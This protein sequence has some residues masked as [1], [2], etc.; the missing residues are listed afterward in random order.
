[1]FL[2][3]HFLG[4]NN[5]ILYNMSIYLC[6]DLYIDVHVYTIIINVIICTEIL[7]VGGEGGGGVNK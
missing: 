1:M 4:S 6:L 2:Q 7:L 3:T 5:E